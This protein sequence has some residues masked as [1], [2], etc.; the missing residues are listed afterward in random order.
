MTITYPHSKT[1]SNRG[2]ENSHMNSTI[3]GPSAT[4]EQPI[5]N[6]NSTI[7]GPSA[8]TQPL[9]NE[10]TTISRPSAPAPHHKFLPRPPEQNP[11]CATTTNLN[12]ILAHLTAV[13]QLQT[14]ML[15]EH[16]V[17]AHED[18][19]Q[20]SSPSYPDTSTKTSSETEDTSLDVTSS[21]ETLSTNSDNSTSTNSSDRQLRPRYPINYNKKLLTKL[22]R[23][24]QIRT[25][26]NIL[27]SLQATDTE[28][29]EEDNEHSD[30]T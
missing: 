30:N 11:I 16:K 24:L 18:T 2:T 10:K 20:E 21:D 17:P 26:N 14:T 25:F 29:K 22:H 27:I 6:I 3:P 4:L 12:Q 13:N 8:A 23:L 9:I 19:L 15:V 28:S 7:P 1:I 5:S